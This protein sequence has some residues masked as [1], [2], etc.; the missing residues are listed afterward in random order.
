MSE[1]PA[2]KYK[3]FD[4][5]D[6]IGDP[7]WS[8]ADPAVQAWEAAHNHDVR[9]KCYVEFGCQAL[10]V[11]HEDLADENERL[12]ADNERLRTE[13]D[14]LIDPD[15]IQAVATAAEKWGPPPE[16]IQ[17]GML[18]ND[19]HQLRRENEIL[20]ATVRRADEM[21]ELMDGFAYAPYD[22]IRNA[23]KAVWPGGS[24]GK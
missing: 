10:A 18:L 3:P 14:R 11:E 8:P 5:A 16:G 13:R 12:L 21:Y 23:L 6:H 19:L 7:P 1:A 15:D 20:K 2:K 17:W 9:L 4:Q 22:A 24:D